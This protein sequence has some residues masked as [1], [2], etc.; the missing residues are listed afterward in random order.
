MR[1]ILVT[2]GAGFIGSNFCHYWDY[3]YPND[4]IWVLDALTYAGNRANLDGAKV[5]FIHGVVSQIEW[6]MDCEG[7]IPDIIVHFAAETHVDN[8][9][10][11]A[12]PFV[13]TNIVGTQAIIDYALKRNIRLHHVSTDEV[14]GSL[15]PNDPPFTEES[16]YNPTSPYAASKA[17]SDHLVRAAVK[18]HG[19]K[20]TISHGCNTFGPRQHAEKL[21]PTLIRT[22]PMPIY[23][24]G[25]NMRE[26]I[27]VEDHCR[28]IDLIIAKG[29]IGESYNIGSGTE[30]ANKYIAELIGGPV[31]F[32]ADRPAHDFRYAMNWGK[33]AKL[34]FWPKWKFK[35]GLKQTIDWYERRA[36]A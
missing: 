36:S 26:W 11:S 27:Y 14:Y 16:R 35:D 2:G 13:R 34:G 33:I 8:S 17:A 28:A 32:V 10:K 22:K 3:A 25:L 15:G 20:A 12:A 5:K 21:I 30:I 6:C 19:L 4:L 31:E 7:I 9:I 23:G 18:T 1:T 24:D 29:D